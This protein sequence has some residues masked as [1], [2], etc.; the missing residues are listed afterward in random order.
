MNSQEKVRDGAGVAAEQYWE[1]L[2]LTMLS[3]AK[4]LYCDDGT[5]IWSI[6]EGGGGGSIRKSLCRIANLPTK[7]P[8][9]TNWGPRVENT[10]IIHESRHVSKEKGE[11]VGW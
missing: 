9:W 7:N 1:V 6:G 11:C 10:A 2:D 4:F 3:I 8:T 5:W